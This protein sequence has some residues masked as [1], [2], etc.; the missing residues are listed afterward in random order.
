LPV[1]VY[2]YAAHSAVAYLVICERN[3]HVAGLAGAG[4]GHVFILQKPGELGVGHGKAE[5][6]G[7]I[8][9][10]RIL[11][12]DEHHAVAGEIPAAVGHH[13]GGNG[14]LVIVVEGDA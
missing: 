12:C 4:D 2:G 1:L 3:R 6:A 8:C 9:G 13:G 5:R 14:A 7:G 11:I 10:Q